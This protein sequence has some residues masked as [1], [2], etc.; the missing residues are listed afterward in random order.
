MNSWKEI[1]KAQRELYI[2]ES[3]VNNK[4]K[5]CSGECINCG[6]TL[7]KSELIENLRV[8]C[9]CGFHFRLNSEQRIKLIFDNDSVKYLDEDLECS[10]ILDFPKYDQKLEKSK[11][12][13]CLKSAVVT[14]VG[15]IFGKKVCFA[16]MDYRFMMG[17]MGSVEG[18]K[19][20]RMIEKSL[21]ESLP[22]MI[23][24]ASGGARIQEGMISLFQMMRVSAKLK[25]HNDKG[26]L[27]ISIA[28]DPTTGGVNASFASLGDIILSEPNATIGFAG[29]RVIQ[30]TLGEKIPENFQKAE[31]V[32]ENGFL[33]CI[34]ER[35]NMKKFISKI[36]DVHSAQYD[37]YKNEEFQ[38]NKVDNTNIEDNKHSPWE[39]VMIARD[40]RR[41][42][43]NVFINNIIDDFIEF[44]G[45]RFFGDDKSMVT[46][47]G[48][49]NEIPV[50]VIANAKG[51]TSKEN[52]KRRMGMAHPEGYRKALRL[53]KQAEK[54][55]R[56]II[57]FVDTP[58]AYCGVCAES[59]GQGQAI[60]SCLYELSNIKVPIIT[61]I[62]GEGGSGGAL[63][64]GVGDYTY[65]YKNSIYSVISP[66]S[67]AAIV[68]KNISRAQEI[69]PFL[70][71]RSSDLMEL[72]LIDEILDEPVDGLKRNELK[73][74]IK[75]KEIL[76]KKIVYLNN[77]DIDTLVK[78]RTYKIRNCVNVK[79]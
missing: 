16:A 72:N 70:K 22:I 53:M 17:S 9:N 76:Y 46:G 57:C 24:S 27:Y 37:K 26:L 54:F 60:A 42:N 6:V 39:T 79:K 74:I 5:K 13:T 65:M 66:E 25:E 12:S 69:A 1:F 23:F 14:G 43:C 40:N 19:L 47:I 4:L 75:L 45:D 30:Q 38:F 36:L 34:V 41:P 10:N 48:F 58:G 33:D 28:T 31:S 8:C 3:N 78:R 20:V 61:I 11:E 59:R 35:K 77:F 44:H 32:L 62:H 15:S 68:Y 52:V 51:E 63:A 73:E 18:E 64:I 2:G 7:S 71:F 21:W 67:A 55:N 29:K 49:L 56:P 50:T